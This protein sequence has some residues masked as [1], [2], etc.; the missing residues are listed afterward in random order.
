[1]KCRPRQ[2]QPLIVEPAQRNGVAR[3][4]YDRYSC[5]QFDQQNVLTEYCSRQARTPESGETLAWEC[6]IRGAASSLRERGPTSKAKRRNSCSPP[7]NDRP[8]RASWPVTSSA[9]RARSP[10]KALVSQPH[11]VE[12]DRARRAELRLRRDSR[13]RPY[14]H[15]RA[16]LRR[17]VV[18]TFGYTASVRRSPRFV[19]AAEKTVHR[20]EPRP[21]CISE[22]FLLA[23]VPSA[24][25][26]SPHR[27]EAVQRD[28]IERIAGAA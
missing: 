9:A 23:H 28:P 19:E 8:S 14:C 18:G 25:K 26:C 22:P 6:C 1:M 21:R 27:R 15:L 3:P 24:A 13:R 2:D 10:M 11:A 4:L 20:C 17:R 5:R 12:H 16:R 7:W